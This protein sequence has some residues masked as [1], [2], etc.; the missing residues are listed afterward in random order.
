[1]DGLEDG[2]VEPTTPSA[3]GAPPPPPPPSSSSSAVSVAAAR[4][5]AA[6]GAPDVE[7]GKKLDVF[8]S[9]MTSLSITIQQQSV[10]VA[11][12]FHMSPP[13]SAGIRSTDRTPRNAPREAQK[14]A[15]DA[16][17]ALVRPTILPDAT[18]TNVVVGRGSPS[19]I[20][21]VTEAILKAGNVSLAPTDAA[22][23]RSM[24]FGLGIGIDCA[25]YVRQ[26]AILAGLLSPSSRGTPTIGDDDLSNL[27]SRGFHLVV[28]YRTARV[29]DIFVLGPRVGQT[30]DAIGHRAIVSSQ[31][32]AV[33]G[34]VPSQLAAQLGATTGPIHV[35]QVDSSWGAGGVAANGG[36]R[37]QTWLYAEST[38]K[39]AWQP[40]VEP[41]PQSYKVT[42]TPY[43]HV[44][45]TGGFGLYR[46]RGR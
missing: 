32:V 8:F 21:M 2:P 30:S 37:R 10:S 23:V 14:D 17:V 3:G 46:G 20:I 12:P 40:P 36:V 5:A 9:Q 22:G 13:Q 1:M 18:L 43:G 4:A 26:A 42:E 29:G 15:R 35:F 27:P 45:G 44:F 34:E 41:P 25:G 11:V 7:I 31:H 28:D 6:R 24:M 39:W 19:E 16:I 33:P 38:G